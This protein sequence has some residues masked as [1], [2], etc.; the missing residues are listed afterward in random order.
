ME[1]ENKTA[2]GV[3]ELIDRIK[4]E[5]ITKGQEQ[6][7]ALLVEARR[8]AADIL[9]KAKSE[10]VTIVREAEDK[11]DKTKSSGQEAVR[12]AGR[13]A[14]LHLTEELRKDFEQ[15]LRKLVG[16]TLKDTEFLKQM[17]LEVARRAMPEDSGSQVEFVLPTEV[18]SVEEL[19]K[20]PDELEHGTL[21][22][23]VLALGGEALR[24]G[25]TFR[26]ANHDTP[27]IRVQIVDQDLQIDLTAD[28][29]TH[30]MLQHLSP[31]FRAIMEGK[32]AS[33][34]HP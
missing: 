26:V 3:Q 9:E 33:P 22:H 5:G 28:T 31:R 13:D 20:S 15:K 34:F 4:D 19:A 11:A 32:K 7:E 14:I 8:Q 27:G 1:N 17:I 24:D 25:L 10:A 23:F 6:A 30:L 29:L 18:A 21:N 16:Q 12:L 2:S